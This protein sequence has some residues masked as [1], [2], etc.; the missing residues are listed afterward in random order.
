MLYSLKSPGITSQPTTTFLPRTIL[1]WAIAGL[2]IQIFVTCFVVLDISFSL[3]KIAG[4]LYGILLFYALV[5]VV[6]SV[7]NRL[8]SARIIKLFVLTLFEKLGINLVFR[9]FPDTIKDYA[10]YTKIYQ[11]SKRRIA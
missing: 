6:D 2:V 5:G 7:K 3:S 9:Y 10:F 4:A 8:N 11:S 1:D